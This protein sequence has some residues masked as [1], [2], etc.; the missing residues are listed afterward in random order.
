MAFS[1]KSILPCS[2]WGADRFFHGLFPS[3]V[4]LSLPLAVAGILLI[5]P[6]ST[7]EGVEMHQG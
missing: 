7:T 1:T 6:D 5:P 4:G 2:R 3:L